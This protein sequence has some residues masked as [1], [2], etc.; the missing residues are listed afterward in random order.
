[1][2]F[3]LDKV[4]SVDEELSEEGVWVILDEESALKVTRLGNKKF[5]KEVSKLSSNNKVVVQ[6]FDELP[7]EALIRVVAKTVLIDWKGIKCKGKVIEYS[8]DNA[9][10]MMT[11]YEEFFDLVV[12][13]S[14]ERETFKR[15]VEIEDKEQLKK[16]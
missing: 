2:A 3:D 5:K 12:E 9:V 14:N 10:Q 4:F 13:L 15:K 6:Y 16:S 11:D 1:M 7:K 8:F